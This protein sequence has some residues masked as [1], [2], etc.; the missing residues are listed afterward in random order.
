MPKMA[1]EVQRTCAECQ[2]SMSPIVI[3]DMA[4]GMASHAVVGPLEYRLPDDRVSFW[5]GRYPTAGVVRAY[6]CA[7]CGRIALYGD[8]PDDYPGAAP[9]PARK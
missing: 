3:M 1:D 5:T 2:G 6:L 9:D 8:N 7:G 4:P